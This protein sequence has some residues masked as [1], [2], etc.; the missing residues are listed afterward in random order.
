MGLCQNKTCFNL[1]SKL[2]AQETGKDIS[3]IE[4]FKTR[5]PVRPIKVKY[6]K[7]EQ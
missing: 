7:R 1:I 3:K 2:I 5:P 4:P 6:W